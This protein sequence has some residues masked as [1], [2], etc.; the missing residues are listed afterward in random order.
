MSERF[1]PIAEAAQADYEALRAAALAGEAPRDELAAARFAR[2][3]LAGVIAWPRAEPVYL[4]ELVGAQRPAWSGAED[5]RE[6]VLG[7]VYGLLVA[8]APATDSISGG[9]GSR[10]PRCYAFWLHA[11]WFCRH[12]HDCRAARASR[13]RNGPATPAT[14]SGS[15]T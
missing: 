5:L 10:R 6:T 12:R 8:R 3:G 1:W 14:A 11:T 13:S 4:G 7:E 2:R 9:C 15:M